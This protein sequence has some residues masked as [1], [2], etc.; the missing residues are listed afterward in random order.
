[1]FHSLVPASAFTLLGSRLI[2][3]ICKR[4]TRLNRRADLRLL[5][6]VTGSHDQAFM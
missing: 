2:S 6:P 5:I 4:T 3:V 1:M